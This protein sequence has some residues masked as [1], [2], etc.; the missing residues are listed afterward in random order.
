MF[1]TTLSGTNLH[2]I[3]MGNLPGH[4]L[5]ASLERILWQ[6]SHIHPDILYAVSND[7]SSIASSVNTKSSIKLMLRDTQEHTTT[8]ATCSC[9]QFAWSPDGKS[10]LYSTGTQYTIVN[11]QDHSSFVVSAESASVPYWSP[12]SRF[13]ILDGLHTLQ[14]INVTN[15]H[16][17]EL[18]SDPT[19]GAYTPQSPLPDSHTLLQPISNS[20]W[21][22]DSQQFLFLTR[23][24]LM[25]QGKIMDTGNGLYTVTIDGNG[26]VLGQPLIVD[27]GNDTQASWTYEDPDT[28]FIF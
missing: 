25:W 10:I 9:T 14:L 22:T 11:I 7:S 12:D 24:R 27:S 28:S 26:R 1:T 20:I 18:L 6:P 21:S 17:Q 19:S 5:P 2:V 23:S 16:H 4:P 13:I 15:Q 3:L 8:I